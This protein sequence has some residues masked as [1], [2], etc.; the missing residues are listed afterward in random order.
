MISY[1]EFYLI[2]AVLLF[3]IGAFGILVKKN[4]IA[5]LMCVGLMLNAVNLTLVVFSRMHGNIEGQVFAIFIVG[6]SA[7]QVALG[8]AIIIN[9]FR[10]FHSIDADVVRE[11]R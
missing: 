1:T 4:T 3:S 6:I 9:M 5:M 7:A 2:L 10:N 11:G 8:T